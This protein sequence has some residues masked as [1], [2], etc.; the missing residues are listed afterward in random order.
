MNDRFCSTCGALNLPAARF[1]QACGSRLHHPAGVSCPDCGTPALPGER[2]CDACGT[3]LPPSAL[4]ILEDTGWRVALPADTDREECIIGRVDPVSG[5]AP[6]IDLSIYQAERYG[7]SRRHARLGRA[8][9]GLTLED[10]NSV[11]LTYIN[12]QRLEPGGA[13]LLKD[14]DRVLLGNLRLIFRQV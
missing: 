14:G 7:V 12:D 3:P 2:F 9:A 8:G 10:L 4:F 11:N 1:C 6:K 5:A 13:I